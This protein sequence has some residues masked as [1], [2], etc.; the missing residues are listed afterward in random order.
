MLILNLYNVILALELIRIFYIKSKWKYTGC[1]KIKFKFKSFYSLLNA[2][3]IDIYIYI[4]YNIYS[5]YNIILEIYKSKKKIH[6]NNIYK[7]NHHIHFLFQYIKIYHRLF[8]L[9]LFGFPLYLDLHLENLLS[10]IIV[11]Q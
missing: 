1:F 8:L 6:N 2:T 10:C 4:I 3:H 7:I 5:I 9:T 11:L